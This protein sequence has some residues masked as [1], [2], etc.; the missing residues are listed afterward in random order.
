MAAGDQRPCPDET[1]ILAQLGRDDPHSPSPWG[2]NG[3]L[4]RGPGGRKP[5]LPLPLG[6]R[7]A[8]HDLLGVEGVD[9]PDAGQGKR[10]TGTLHERGADGVAGL[11]DHIK[12]SYPVDR[13]RG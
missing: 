10:T 5:Q 7:A 11:L 13:S 1:H 3:R 6:D 9:P 12:R 2:Q 4:D 8:N